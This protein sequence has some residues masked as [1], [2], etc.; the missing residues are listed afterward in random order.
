MSGTEEHGLRA[1]GG[2][3]DRSGLPVDPFNVSNQ[4]YF[5]AQSGTE[6]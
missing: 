4:A 6:G 2:R 1:E 5:S 3:S